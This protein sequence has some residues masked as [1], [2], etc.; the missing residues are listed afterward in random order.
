MRCW[1]VSVPYFCILTLCDV[2]YD[3]TKYILAHHRF[4]SFSSL[5]TAFHRRLIFFI[6][7]QDNGKVRKAKKYELMVIEVI[8]F[9]CITSDKIE[10]GG[11]KI[12][13]CASTELP[14]Q[15]TCSLTPPSLSSDLSSVT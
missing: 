12:H 9:L 8:D 11:Q 1:H 2:T 5:S 7:E 10:I 15:L 13:H 4:L 6:P 3:V 14:N